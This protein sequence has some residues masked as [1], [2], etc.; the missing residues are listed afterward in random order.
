[1][2]GRSFL[3]VALAACAVALLFA[4]ACAFHLSSAEPNPRIRRLVDGSG[5]IL[6]TLGC[7]LAVATVGLRRILARLRQENHV[8]RRSL[9]ALQLRGDSERGQA[10]VLEK[11]G[12]L[13]EVFNQTRDLDAVLYEAVAAL[14]TILHVDVIV[15]QLYSDR[16]SRFFTR[17]EDGAHD[18]NLGSAI[19]HDV[20]ERGRS[21]L[22]NRL[23]STPRYA[24]LVR[25]GFHSIIVAPLM[26]VKR[27]EGPAGVGLIAA[28]SRT[29]RDFVSHELN[30]LVT[31]ARQ[32]GLIIEDAHL[33]KKTEHLALHDGLL[34]EI[35]NRRYFIATLD[36]EIAKARETRRPLALVMADV[37][38]FKRHNDTYGHPS[39]DAAL[40]VIAN[41]MLDNTRGLDVV[42]RYGG[43][44]FVIV[45]PETDED[46]AATVAD[47]IRRRVENVEVPVPDSTTVRLSISVG[48]ALYPRDADTANALIRAADQALY[49]AKSAGKNRLI[50]ASAMADMNA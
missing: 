13:I 8:L 20:V 46:G 36:A 31:F 18:V 41:V 47:T 30:L 26:R 49:R 15:L 38:N 9:D 29:P 28:L 7:S 14:R 37:D 24:E 10:A 39:G 44:E 34:T 23:Q 22:I 19:Q 2:T 50:L 6:A 3:I 25:S 48:I 45:L 12:S 32:A 35:F 27:G 16:E 21:R 1:M 33:Y 11:L 42:A 4:G 17:I 40:R 5:V 43:E